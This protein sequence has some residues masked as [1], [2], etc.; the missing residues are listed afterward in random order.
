LS[1]VSRYTDFIADRLR[2]SL[3]FRSELVQFATEF[4]YANI[5]PGW[6]AS[7]FIQVA[8]H[9]RRGDFLRRRN[10]RKGF[11]TATPLYL[12]R[13][14]GYFVER[15]AR[16]QFVVASNDIAWCR[17]HLQSL[18]WDRDRV[19]VTFSE[20]HSA[21]E[22]MALLTSCNHAVI[23]TGTYG[24]WAAW[25]INGITVYYADFPRKGSLLSK[26]SHTEDY[27]PPNWIAISG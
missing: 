11:T 24:W 5:P 8:V 1:D 27:Y 2:R 18:Y 4:L 6:T 14:L 3:K 25:L 13:A 15:F 10:I 17:A 21:G 16:I 23:T 20:G 7:S 26:R 12:R 22:D 19:N 9:V